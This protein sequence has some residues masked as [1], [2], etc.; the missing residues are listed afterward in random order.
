MSFQNLRNCRICGKL[1]TH[2]RG[3]DACDSCKKNLD[4]VYHR[5]REVL[6]DAE[7]GQEYD[8]ISLAEKL[9]VEPV[10][11]HI[12][13]E[14][15]LFERDGLHLSGGEDRKALAREFEMELR[16]KEQE[17]IEKKDSTGGMFMDIRRGKRDQ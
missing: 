4:E 9:D 8:N 10:M 11:I 17:K 1:Y 5:A 2:F 7:P 13:A 6:R 15:G 14:E 12:L 16:K 3:P